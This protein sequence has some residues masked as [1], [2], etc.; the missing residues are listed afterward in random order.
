MD[1][2]SNLLQSIGP[3][4]I[5]AYLVIVKMLEV[6]HKKK[7][8]DGLSTEDKINEIYKLVKDL[9][10]WH[11]KEGTDG[12]KVWYFRP[13]LEKVIKDLSNAIN[14]QTAALSSVIKDQERTIDL[15]ERVRDRK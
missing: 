6:F 8:S 15:L 12:V 7:N 14:N 5:F 13:S 2:L 10:N 9:H 11:N 3:I 4:G 1:D